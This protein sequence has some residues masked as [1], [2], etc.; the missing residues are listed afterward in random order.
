VSDRTVPNRARRD[1]G[2]QAALTIPDE[3]GSGADERQAVMG[4]AAIQTL[5]EAS[6]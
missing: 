1:D 3:H 5:T 4:H 6:L 2:A